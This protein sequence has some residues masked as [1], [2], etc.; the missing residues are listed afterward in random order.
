M[1]RPLS[2]GRNAAMLRFLIVLTICSTVGLQ[3]W[4]TLFDNFAVRVVGLDG[5]HIG[6]IQSVREI[7]GFLALLV[8]YVMLIIREHRIS[9]LSI[10]AL[11]FGL[12]SVGFFPSF[13]GLIMTTLVVSFGF[14]YYE[15]TN[16]SLTLQYFDH[17]TAPHVFGRLRSFAAATN[18][19]VGVFVFFAAGVFS[20]NEM[21]MLIGG[22]IVLASVWALTQNP[23]HSDLPPQHR[24]M[25]FRRRYWLYY[26][27]TFLAGARRQ[28]FVAFAV[29]LLVKHFD[30][31]LKEIAILFV[32]NNV[33]NYFAA[34]LIGSSIV[35]FGE[36]WVLSTEYFSLILIFMGYALAGSKLLVAG[37]Y[38]VD[39]V[40]FNFAMGIRTFFQKV[41]DP[42][43]IAP[44][45]AAGFTI[46]HIAAVVLPAIGGMLW[47]IDYR[48]PFYA[49]A[50]LSLLSLVAVQQIPRQIRAARKP[51]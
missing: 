3:A 2:N 20:Y 17:D 12:A 14:H 46:N 33:I 37:L 28:I 6:I 41:A 45:M 35:R 38:I 11:G 7:P 24:K 49:G 42:S 8:V 36:R 29:F 48:I 31:S 27:L 1:N 44:S 23:T 18:V 19:A 10:L 40:L 34:P 5:G 15:T 22:L 39:N 50:G 21:Y 32:V 4:R 43:D 13:A 26:L 47:M 16:Q 30:F 9:A 51:R 25:I